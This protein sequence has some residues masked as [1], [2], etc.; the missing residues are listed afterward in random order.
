VNEHVVILSTAP[1]LEVA[2]DLAQRLVGARLAACVNVL[3]GA[4]SVYRWQDEVAVEP[5]LVLVIKTRASLADEAVRALVEAH[6][7]DVPEALVLPVSGGHAPY[8][9]WL[10][11]ATR[12]G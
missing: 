2:R 12:G 6:P 4:T 5:E 9:A 3:P 8:L 7:Y 1:S 11:E 10:S